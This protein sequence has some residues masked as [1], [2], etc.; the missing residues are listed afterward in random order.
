MQKKHLINAVL[1]ISLAGFSIVSTPV[2]AKH[3]KAAAVK[4]VQPHAPATSQLSAGQTSFTPE[5]VKALQS[6]IHDYIVQ[7]PQILR[8]ASQALRN[9][10]MDKMQ[11]DTKSQIVKHTSDLLNTDQ[12]FAIGNPKGDVVMVDVF[13]YQCGHCKAMSPTVNNLVKGDAKL[14]VIFMDWPIFGNDSIYAA[15]AAVVAKKYGK[16]QEMHDA[17]FAADGALSSDKVL[18][19]AKSIGLDEKKFL[20]DINDKATDDVIKYNAQLAKDLKLIA[21]PAFIFINRQGSKVEFVL[22]EVGSDDLVKAINKVRG[23]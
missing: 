9:Q 23:K 6:I 10:E 3:H 13:D 20:Q 1:A 12:H 2:Y 17:L 11:S 19:I 4:A 18:Q 22:G 7:N 16:Y 5:Q 21:T 15:K 14:Q 8:E